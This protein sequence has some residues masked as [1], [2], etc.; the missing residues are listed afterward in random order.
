MTHEGRIVALQGLGYTPRQA[1][2][3]AVVAVHS[4][5][6]LRR[7][8]LAFTGR[9]HGAATTE[10]LHT[11]VARRHA[12]VSPYDPHTQ[13]YHLTARGLYGAIEQ[14]H[15]RNRRRVEWPTVVRKLMTLDFVLAHR[16]AAWFGTEDD[17]LALVVD[18]FGLAPSILPTTVYRARRSNAAPTTRV[19]VDK[20]P[21]LI[22]PERST[23]WVAYVN[24]G[25]PHED[26]LAVFLRQYQP[27][28]AALPSAGVWYV[29]ADGDRGERA[30]AVLARV[31]RGA[32]RERRHGR[33]D[34]APRVLPDA[35]RA[36]TRGSGPA[37][38]NANSMPSG[39]PARGSTRRGTTRC[40]A[41][42]CWT[43]TR[44]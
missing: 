18:R 35:P 23:V 12:V 7:Q 15:N 14:E 3:L 29:G 5:Y 11:L 17:K 39:P 34:A 36:S 19:C 41:R 33:P 16:D 21:W 31:W 30:Q 20:M 42:G 6:F 38:R 10:F 43:E 24:V 22:S 13:V 28:L 40:T 25:P 32:T 44:R 8:Y 1:A 27:L 2:F 26:R 9:A 4:G 37:S